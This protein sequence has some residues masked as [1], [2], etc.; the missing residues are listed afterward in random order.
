MYDARQGRARPKSTAGVSRLIIV[1]LV[2]IVVM[3]VIIAI[4]AWKVFRYRSEKT[5]CEQAMKSARDGLIIEYLAHWEAGSVED[6]MKTLDEV[7]PERAN[8]CPSG[9]TVYLVRDERGIFQPICGLH[10]SD[11]ALRA[12]LNASRAKDLLEEGLRKARRQ[13]EGEPES[14]KIQL[15]GKTLECVRVQEVPALRRGTSTT[16]GFKGVVALYGLEGEGAFTS[17]AVRKGKISY[18]IYADEDY[19]AFWRAGEGWQGT[20]YPET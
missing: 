20:A 19:C 10:D 2:L 17:G 15:N 6:A 12:R 18:F 4:P 7:M 14:V 8:I 5:A 9:G 3:L 13:Q 16:D 1:L 11:K